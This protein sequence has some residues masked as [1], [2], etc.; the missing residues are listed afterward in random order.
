M[1]PTTASADGD[2]LLPRGTV[3]APGPSSSTCGGVGASSSACKRRRC[4]HRLCPRLITAK[5][6]MA[7]IY[8][9]LTR[10]PALCL[11]LSV[12]LPGSEQRGEEKKKSAS[13]TLDLKIP[14]SDSP[15]G[16][17]G[18]RGATIRRGGGGGGDGGIRLFVSLHLTGIDAP[19]HSHSRA[20]GRSR[21]ERG[22]DLRDLRRRGNARD[23]ARGE[24]SVTASRPFRPGAAAC[25]R[26][27][28][29]FTKTLS[30]GGVGQGH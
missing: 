9:P 13:I 29:F 12:G 6:M 3:R 1:R 21:S 2:V 19:H 18:G 11:R 10:R 26:R 7:L 20:D 24:D 5:H 22:Q 28:A 14:S 27:T 17:A 16:K 8:H 15:P 30:E 4:R 23:A 25:N